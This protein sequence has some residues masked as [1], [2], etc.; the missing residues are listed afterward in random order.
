MH[1]KT[2]LRLLATSLIGLVLLVV[3]A[4]L[5]TAQTAQTFTSDAALQIGT[6]VQIDESA[7]GK[8]KAAKSTEL[9]KMYGVVIS[10]S[11]LP[12]TLTGGDANQVYVSPGGKYSVLVSNQNGAIKVG[13]NITLSDL[14]GVGMKSDTDHAYIFGKAISGFD[15]KTNAIGQ[16]QLKYSDG[17]AAQAVGIG[18]IEANIE[19]KKNPDIKSTKTKLPPVL[20]RLGQQIA[21][22]TVSPFRL[23]LSMAIV[24]VTIIVAIVVLYSG[25]KNSITAIGRNPLSKK[26][27]FRGLLEI[28][29][30]SFIVLIIGLFTVY[31]LLK[32]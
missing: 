5:V 14:S 11:D 31:L 4:V 21:D 27:I 2:R 13:D 17:K 28:I 20:E 16:A 25:V 18:L 1:I 9:G 32:L 15:G 8:V 30:T 12:Y 6:I 26:S 29:L 19:I 24:T 7:K 3:P 23:Y 22:K 10:P